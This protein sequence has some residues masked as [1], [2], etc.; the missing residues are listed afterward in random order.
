MR[1]KVSALTSDELSEPRNTSY[2]SS[3]GFGRKRSRTQC[4]DCKRPRMLG[5]VRCKYHREKSRAWHGFNRWKPGGPG[6]PPL[7]VSYGAKES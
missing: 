5:G 7:E 3:L 2:G 1:F 4:R 6:R